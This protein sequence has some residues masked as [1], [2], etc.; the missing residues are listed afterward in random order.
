MPRSEMRRPS[1]PPGRQRARNGGQ[2]SNNRQKSREQEANELKKLAEGLES[3][4]AASV[5]TFEDLPL[6]RL[7][8]KGDKWNP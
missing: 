7:T 5:S 6:S 3:L 4:D 2:F 1:G 8:L